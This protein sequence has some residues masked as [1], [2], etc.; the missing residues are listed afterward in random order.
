M[1]VGYVP[2]SDDLRQPSDRRRFCY[3]AER[4]GLKFEVARPTGSYDI[5]VLTQAAD[6]SEWS[7]FPTGRGKLVYDL[8]DSYLMIPRFDVKAMLRGTAKFVA[9]QSRYWQLSFTRSIQ[10]MCRRADAV[11]CSTEEQRQAILPYCRNVHPILDFHRSVV[12][13]VKTDYRTDEVFNFVWEGQGRNVRT[14]RILRDVL[15][16]VARQRRFA[17]HLVT[18][19]ECPLGLRSIGRVQTKRLIRRAVGFEEVYLYE[20]NETTASLICTA[21]DLAVIPVPLDVPLYASK[22]ENKLLLFWRMGV[23]VVASASPAYARVMDQCGL[24]MVCRTADD[25]VR[26]LTSY[27]DDEKARREAAQ[28]GRHYVETHCSEEALVRRWDDVFA[29]IL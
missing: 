23:P 27:M 17:L 22:P 26:T 7:R 5:V 18:D 13:T 16:E 2:L 10:R 9:R 14:F 3:Y 1:R 11:I 8:I 29:S 12:R 4:R 19:L 28:R 15:P 21:C 24:P 20:W 6:L 25:W